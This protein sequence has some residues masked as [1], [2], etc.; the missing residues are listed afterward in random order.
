MLG[1]LLFCLATDDLAEKE[2]AVNNNITPSFSKNG[3]EDSGSVNEQ[4]GWLSPIAPPRGVLVG[5]DFSDAVMRMTHGRA[6]EDPTSVS[7]TQP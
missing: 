4:D 3:V 2:Q 1:S 5:M 7:S 6:P